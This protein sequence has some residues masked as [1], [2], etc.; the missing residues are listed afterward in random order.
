MGKLDDARDALIERNRAGLNSHSG[1]SLF[2]RGFFN[3]SG[4]EYEFICFMTREEVTA[5]NYTFDE[6]ESGIRTDNEDQRLL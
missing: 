1:F 2:N 5:W 4:M 6:W 3:R